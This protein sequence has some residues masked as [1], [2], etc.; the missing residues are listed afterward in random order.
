MLHMASPL[1][2]FE[3][4]MVMDISVHPQ[5]IAYLSVYIVFKFGREYHRIGY[6]FIVT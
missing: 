3:I 2:P 6:I 5:Y 4:P 1:S